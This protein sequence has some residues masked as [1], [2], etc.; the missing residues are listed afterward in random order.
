MRKFTSLLALIFLVAC[1][2]NQTAPA[3]PMPTLVTN[4]ASSTAETDYPA[5]VTDPFAPTAYPLFQTTAPSSDHVV[6]PAYPV[7]QPTGLLTVT[8]LSIITN[9]LTPVDP[10]L[11]PLMPK[12]QLE[13]VTLF[14]E[15]TGWALQSFLTPSTT[16]YYYDVERK[17][18][19]TTQGF[20]S[21]QDVSPLP[22]QEKTELRKVFFLN[23]NSAVAIFY[24][25]F[26]PYQANTELTGV[27]T[28]DGGR[29]WQV[30]ETMRFTC[31]LRSPA[32]V[33]MLDV[34]YGWM[35]A[36][37]DGAMGSS[38]LA[39]FR[40]MDGGLQWEKVY[41]TVDRIQID[42]Q[43]AIFAVSNPFSNS[44]FSSND[45][46]TALYATGRLF[47][48]E[49]GGKSWQQSNIP[50]PP[51]K[52]DLDVKAGMGKYE[53]YVTI[54]QFWTKKDGVMVGRYYTELQIPPAIPTGIPI[55]EFLYYTHDGGKTWTFSRSPARTGSPFFLNSTIGWYLGKSD[56]G[57]TMPTQLYQT[58]DGG[59]SWT[60]ILSDCPLPLGSVIHFINA[61]VG[62]ASVTG[63]NYDY[64]FDAR[65]SERPPYFFFT[66]DGGHTW[67][68]VEPVVTP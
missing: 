1:G 60:Q 48:S 10:T 33:E 7:I 53:P 40:T 36:E 24:R 29:T 39:F 57:P 52:S 37:D 27:R 11:P 38:S 2:V 8:P 56:P 66:K 45:F 23:A 41:D 68:Q 28:S 3:G 30:G 61:Q 9:T 32:Q 4:S 31:C 6:T 5:P 46:N 44:G 58:T 65:A 51:S 21:W 22:F 34:N 55:S 59:Q 63:Y 18:L 64:L 47:R 50:I 16:G 67:H 25:N 35:M 26:L 17:V 12:V 14:N 20:Q 54:P 19:R 43:S 15:S 42:S 13:A 49:D 62:Y